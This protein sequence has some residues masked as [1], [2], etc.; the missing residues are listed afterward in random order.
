[1]NATGRSWDD[2]EYVSVTPSMVVHGA[3]GDLESGRCGVGF[4]GAAGRCSGDAEYKTTIA[5]DDHE[6]YV[7][8]CEEHAEADPSSTETVQD[9]DSA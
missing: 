8:L 2:L 9:G 5:F 3:M 7:P 4:H 1:M 6:E